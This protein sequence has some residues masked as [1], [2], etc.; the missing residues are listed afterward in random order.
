MYIS[1]Y[2]GSRGMF[3]FGTIL[4][5]LMI[6]NSFKKRISIFSLLLLFIFIIF[7]LGFLG[8]LRYS[9]DGISFSLIIDTLSKSSSKLN[10]V[11]LSILDRRFDSYFPNLLHV[12]DNINKFEFRY[13]F[14]YVNI[15]LQYVPRFIWEDKP[16]TLVREANNILQL[17]VSG[18]TGFASLFEA[19]INFGPFGLLLNSVLSSIVLVFF[20]K[21]YIYTIRC[22][23][24]VLYIF[25]LTI[26]NGIVFQFF[27]IAWHY[28]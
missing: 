9:R 28:S 21:L 3:I 16:Y 4:P 7:I 2:S 13:G 6:Y 1:L 25:T 12:F 23:S 10:Y 5:V 17:Q 24:L 26:G 14:D 11:F 19:W 8:I 22:N 15:F 18:G 20:Q 27:Y